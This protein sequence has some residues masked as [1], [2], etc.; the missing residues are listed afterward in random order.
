MGLISR[1]S[2]QLAVPITEEGAT[3]SMTS[4]C[5]AQGGGGGG[6]EGGSSCTSSDEVT[7]VPF[8]L[9]ISMALFLC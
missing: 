6:R 3:N 9:L 4:V 5:V 2:C 1:L 8:S 7:V